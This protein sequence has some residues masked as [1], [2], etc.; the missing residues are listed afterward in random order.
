MPHTLAII[1]VDAV[2]GEIFHVPIQQ[3]RAFAV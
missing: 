3:A 1:S 2:G